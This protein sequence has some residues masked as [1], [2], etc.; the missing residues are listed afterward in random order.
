MCSGSVGVVGC[1]RKVCLRHICCFVGCGLNR[2]VGVHLV[3]EL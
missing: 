2:V 3:Y 1:Y